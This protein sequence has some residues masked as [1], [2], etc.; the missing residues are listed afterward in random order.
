MA[1]GKANPTPETAPTPAPA[2]PSPPAPPAPMHLTLAE[3]KHRPIDAIEAD[4]ATAKQLFKD[5]NKVNDE[6]EEK[7]KRQMLRR[8]KAQSTWT[9]ANPG[10]P[11]DP[12]GDYPIPSK[13]S[14]VAKAFHKQHYVVSAL[15]KELDE[16]KA[17]AMS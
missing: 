11:F 10:E 4:Q 3:K 12:D 14:P 16:A 8:E 9:H 13:D 7:R 17:A 2:V 15:Q 5:Q 1:D 6:Y